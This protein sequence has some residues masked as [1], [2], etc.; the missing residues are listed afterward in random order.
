MFSHCDP[1]DIF[2]DGWGRKDHTKEGDAGQLL[3][4]HA[5]SGAPVAAAQQEDT[6]CH[7]KIMDF[8]L[9]C[10]HGLNY[11]KM[12]CSDHGLLLFRL[13]DLWKMEPC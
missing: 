5:N 10:A 8:Q 6:Y 4:I 1:S 9:K 11:L 7:L 13:W 3:Q 12:K 2:P